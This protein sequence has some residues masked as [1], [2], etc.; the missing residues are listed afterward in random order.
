MPGMTGERLTGE[1]RFI[2]PELPVIICPDYDENTEQQ[3]IDSIG[4]AT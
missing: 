1:V 2:H 4:G 3:K